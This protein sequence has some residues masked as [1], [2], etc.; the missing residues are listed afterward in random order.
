[1]KILYPELVLLKTWFIENKWERKFHLK[2]K[3]FLY[4]NGSI[5]GVLSKKNLNIKSLLMFG[6][7][8]S[9]YENLEIKEI[10]TVSL[11]FGLYNTF[12]TSETTYNYLSKFFKDNKIQSKHI[13]FEDYQ[14]RWI[15][16]ALFG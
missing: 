6:D 15:R 1:M 13:I 16:N 5:I 12:K 8:L 14:T 11:K 3:R 10:S 9:R 2:F 4:E 7:N